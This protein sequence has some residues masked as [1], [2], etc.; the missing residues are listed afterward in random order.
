MSKSVRPIFKYHGGKFY[1]SSWIISHFPENYQEM[2]YLEPFC[3][4]A[5]VLLNKK[6]SKIEVINDL[7]L[8][9][10]QI[11]RALRDEPKE[12][13]RRLNICKYCEETFQKASNK[14]VFEDY[15]DQATNEFIARRM[16][17]G[18]MKKSFAWS[19]RLRGGQPGDVNAWQTSL[20]TLNDLSERIKEV[21]AYNDSAIKI[22]KDFNS[23]DTLVYCDPPYVADTRVSK[24]VYTH[25]MSNEEHIELAEFLNNFKGKVLISGYASPLYK[26]IYKNWNV[27][28][29]KIANHSSQQKE[30]EKKEELL[31]TNF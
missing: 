19:E 5:N 13:I 15:L 7:D 20:K 27:S 17:R 23:T 8:N 11:Y 16:S 24:S 2:T 25:E 28:K 22:M 18:G 31:F 3:G 10:I 12:F 30:K 29:K 9:I 14:E 21:Y 6:K 26:K 1:L 4:G